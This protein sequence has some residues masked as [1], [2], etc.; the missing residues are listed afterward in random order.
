MGDQTI[1][2]A[3]SGQKIPP[4]HHNS[5]K[6]ALSEDFLPRNSSGIVTSVAGAIGSLLYRWANVFTDKLTVGD[7]ANQPL[8]LDQSGDVIRI[9][10]N[11][12][13]IGQIPKSAASIMAK[14]QVRQ[15]L[16]VSSGWVPPP[17]VKRL[18]WIMCG[19]G[20]GGGGGSSGTGL[21]GQGGDGSMEKIY[22]VD[23][24]DYAHGSIK[25]AFEVGIGGG[26]GNVGNSGNTGG[27]TY[28]RM[29]DYGDTIG[30]DP[31]LATWRVAGGAPGATNSSATKTLSPY[32]NALTW[33]NI[34]LGGAAG[35]ASGAG[36]TGF[37]S[38]NNL[39][40]NGGT[41]L[42]NYSG[43]GGGGA[44]YMSSVFNTGDVA[45]RGGN[46]GNGNSTN[47][48]NGFSSGA[49]G[50]GGGANR[51]GGNGANGLILLQCDS[52]YDLSTYVYTP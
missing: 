31:A 32:S 17:D 51:A 26:G 16:D 19:G 47:G 8:V 40:G 20:G 13:V 37:G 5:I 46:G 1:A 12:V 49:G 28:V 35:T 45:G 9:L 25:F 36:S 33:S 30:V 43:G 39:S 6:N 2:T 23:I 7:T 24:S 27:I 15:F 22:E 34:C 4:S 18:K 21:G 38:P 48:G 11:S 29:Y 52:I 50:G 10:R 42:T 3:A 41:A 44:G 14:R